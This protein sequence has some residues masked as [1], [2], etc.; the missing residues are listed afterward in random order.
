MTSGSAAIASPTARGSPEVRTVTIA[1]RE[2]ATCRGWVPG[3]PGTTPAA[4]GRGAPQRRGVAPPLHP[5]ADGGLRQPD[6]VRDPGVGTPAVLLELLDDRPGDVVQDELT[7]PDRHRRLP[8][9][10]VPAA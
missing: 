10:A 1:W 3:P 4:R 7:L 8:A 6:G 9:V 2:K 5:L